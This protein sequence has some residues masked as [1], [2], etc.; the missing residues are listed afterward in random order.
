MALHQPSQNKWRVDDGCLKV[1]PYLK[2]NTDGCIFLILAILF[3]FL[4][5]FLGDPRITE[6]LGL[7]GTPR[8]IWS[9]LCSSRATSRWLR[10][11]APA[12]S[13]CSR[14]CLWESRL[15]CFGELTGVRS[16]ACTDRGAERAGGSLTSAV[17]VRKGHAHRVTASPARRGQAPPCV[18]FPPSRAQALTPVTLS[19]RGMT[20]A[21]RGSVRGAVSWAPKHGPAEDP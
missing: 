8:P 11:A 7:E 18:P 3:Q 10:G 9:S 13:P 21:L 20:R 5:F 14:R 1:L 4:F 16:T 6:T 2:K 19:V 12:T 17:L 15:G